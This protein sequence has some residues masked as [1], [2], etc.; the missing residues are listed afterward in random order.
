MRKRVGHR[1]HSATFSRFNGATNS[2]GN[3]QYENPGNWI[4]V[5][6]VWPCEMVSASGGETI[7]GRQVT[8]NTSIV[9]FGDYAAAKYVLE[10]DRVT[11]DGRVLGVAAAYD[12]EGDK[13]ELRV[14]CREEI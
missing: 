11:V 4:A 9:L 1:N 10:S 13:M 7:R 8:A 5:L 6:K 12:A 2:A 3:P 14:E